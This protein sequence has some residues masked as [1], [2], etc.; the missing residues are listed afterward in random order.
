MHFS[1]G[2]PVLEKL[3]SMVLIDI[4]SPSCYLVILLLCE[5]DT[6]PY[7]INIIY[8]KNWCIV[9][10]Q[11]LYGTGTTLVLLKKLSRK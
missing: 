11:V 8:N 2:W 3:K 10:I 6:G 7:P 4:C 9:V 5:E 1:Y